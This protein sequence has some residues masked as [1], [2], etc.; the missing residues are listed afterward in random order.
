MRSFEQFVAEASRSDA[1]LQVDPNALSRA[2]STVVDGL[3]HT[4]LLALTIMTIVRRRREDIPTADV[5]TWTLATLTRHFDYLNLSRTRL[6][7]SVPLRRRC[8]DALVF[9]ENAELVGIQEAPRRTLHITVQGR[10]FVRKLTNRADEAGVLVRQ[11]ERAYRAVEQT[12][13]FVL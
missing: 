11:L 10:A 5:A 6:Q 8:A 13:A 7:W 4:P 3:F 2:T 9:L 12:G 1:R